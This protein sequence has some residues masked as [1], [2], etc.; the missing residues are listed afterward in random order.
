MAI[1]KTSASDKAGTQF[2]EKP[3]RNKLRVRKARLEVIRGPDLGKKRNIQSLHLMVGVSPDCDMVLSDPTISWQHFELLTTEDG[4]LLRDLDSKNGT[5]IRGIRVKQAV[6]YG[7][8][9]IDIGNSTL[10]LSVYDEHEE[11]TL[12]RKN[13]FGTMI[14]RSATIRQVFAEL[15][16]VAPSDAVLLLEGESGTGKDLAAEN[17]HRFSPRKDKPFVVFDCGAVSSTLVESEL[18]GH[19]KGAFTGADRDRPG[20]IESANGG[21]IFLNEIGEIPLKLQTR[22]LRLL[23]TW[24]TRRVGENQYRKVDVRLIAATNRD[25]KN[26][27]ELKHFREDLYYRLTVVRIRLPAL[28][29]R[30]EDIALL[31]K[32]FIAER[33]SDQDPDKIITDQVLAMFLNHLW[34]G[35]IRELRNVVDRLILFPKRPKSALSRDKEESGLVAIPADFLDLS[36]RDFRDQC[37]RTYLSAVIDSCNGVMTEAAAKADL[38]RM[39]FYRLV[40]KHKL[41]K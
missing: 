8:E 2:I 18:F 25:L 34:P 10:L 12:S 35:N 15:E 33:A 14:G 29:D 6:L 41:T 30:R 20:V 3:T 22:L 26:E 40:K 11:F 31:A 36:F 1:D 17:I 9:Q 38:P 28:R 21:T 37:E 24:E 7:G 39:T 13:S 5:D 19:R 23:D 27:V 32:K 16:Q 4:C